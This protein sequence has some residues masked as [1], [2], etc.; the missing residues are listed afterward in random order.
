[1]FLSFTQS[2]QDEFTRTRVSTDRG[3]SVGAS[4][5]VSECFRPLT[6]NHIYLTCTLP[7]SILLITLTLISYLPGSHLTFVVKDMLL[8]PNAVERTV[9]KYG[10]AFKDALT[11]ENSQSSS[12]YRE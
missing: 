6:T 5:C 7:W 10:D 9:F 4:W 12:L 11:A 2:P 1:M 8:C 3:R